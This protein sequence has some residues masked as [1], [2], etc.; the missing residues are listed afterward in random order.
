MA[1]LEKMRTLGYKELHL[2]NNCCYNYWF[3]IHYEDG[4]F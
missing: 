2:K 4:F 1:T 3:I